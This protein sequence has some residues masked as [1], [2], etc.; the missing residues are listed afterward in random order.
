MNCKLKHELA[1]FP[2]VSLIIFVTISSSVVGLMLALAVAV[3]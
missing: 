3:P 2:H 1:T